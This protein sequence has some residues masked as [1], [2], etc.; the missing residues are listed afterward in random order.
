MPRRSR[1][2]GILEGEGIKGVLVCFYL[3]ID[4]KNS[5]MAT[6]FVSAQLLWGIISIIFGIIVFAFPKILNYLVALYLI[7]T[8]VLMVLPSLGVL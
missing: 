3:K 1:I 6:I 8:G 2:C 4:N 7:I 5:K